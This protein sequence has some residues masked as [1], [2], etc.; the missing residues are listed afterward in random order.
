MTLANGLLHSRAARLSDDSA[1]TALA[2]QDIALPELVGRACDRVLSRPPTPEELTLFTDLLRDGYA[3]RRTG[4]A[5]LP[6]DV[7]R[8]RVAWSNHLSPEATRLKLAEEQAARAGDSPTPRLR[9][10]WRQRF[11]DMLW[12]LMSSPEFVF[13]P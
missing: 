7:K 6:M 1:F 4:A 8:S 12:A 9:E 2:L 3:D 10:G 11:E 5:P 13:V